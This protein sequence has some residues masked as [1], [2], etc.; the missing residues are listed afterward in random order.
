LSARSGDGLARLAEATGGV[1]FD[2]PGN[3]YAPILRRVELDLRSRY[4]LG[5]RVENPGSSGRCR[6]LKVEV[7]RPSV[8]VRARTEFFD[9]Q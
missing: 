1:L 9:P 5:F 8:W 4:I 3:D 7:A 6:Q 2:P